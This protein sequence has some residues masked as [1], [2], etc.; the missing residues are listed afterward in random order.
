MD[1]YV[2]V[3]TLENELE[4]GLLDSILT[5]RQIPH[6]MRS[7]H[8]TAFDGLFQAQKGWGHVSV[9]PRYEEEVLEIVASLREN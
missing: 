1:D 9:P 8:D 3:A 7:Y 5:E 2:K 6:L 4:A